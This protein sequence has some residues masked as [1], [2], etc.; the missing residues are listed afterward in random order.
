M[1]AGVA[2]SGIFEQI[3]SYTKTQLTQFPKSTS[4]N[5][6]THV[7]TLFH[8]PTT[9]YPNSY[10]FY[11]LSYNV[12]T[13]FTMS[14]DYSLCSAGDYL[15][16]HL[17]PVEAESSRVQRRVIPSQVSILFSARMPTIYTIGHGTHFGIV[18]MGEPK[19]LFDLPLDG[20]A[21]GNE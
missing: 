1:G 4:T 21:S 16:I 3:V 12:W 7:H 9:I 13:I 11:L 19:V 15:P 10:L 20:P 6:L 5:T 17:E 2:I 14:N 18:W 8:R